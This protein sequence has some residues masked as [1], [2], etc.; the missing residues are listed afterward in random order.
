MTEG[1]KDIPEVGDISLENIEEY[2]IKLYLKTVIDAGSKGA[3]V[4]NH[5]FA[6]VLGN[7]IG[8]KTKCNTRMEFYGVKLV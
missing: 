5:D 6:L 8:G 7:R 3:I 4:R 2:L 1:E